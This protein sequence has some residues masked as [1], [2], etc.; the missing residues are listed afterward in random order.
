MKYR[1]LNLI[2][3][4]LLLT[5]C[6][7]SFLDR[8]PEG[9]YVDVTYYTSDNAL[10]QATAPLYNRAWFDL[11][12]RA[13]VPLGSNRANDNFSRWGYPEFTN[14]KV[15]ALSTNLADAWKGFYSVITISN[16]VISAVNTKCSEDVSE[17]A[18]NEAI[19]EA[20]LMRACAYFYMVRLWGPVIIIEDNDK[21][22]ANPIQPLNRE[23]DVLEFVIRDL[24][25]AAENLP[26]TPSAKGRVTSWG[27]KGMLAKVYLA[28]SGWNGGA[29]NESDLQKCKELAA[30]VINNSGLKLYD[31]YEDLFKY[32]HNNN[33]E[34]LIAMQWVPLGD[35]GVCNT[36]LADLAGNSKMTGGVN[37]WSSYQASI[38]MLQQYETADTLRRNA[39]FCTNGTY[40]PYICIADGGYTYDGTTSSIKKGVPGGPD[41]D[42][43]GYIQSMNSP[44]NTYILRLADVYLTYAEA[45]LGNN[46]VLNSGPGLEAL[47]LV[48]DRARI[49]RKTGVT[50]E[51]IIRE[52]RV[53]FS[54]EYCNWYD[55]VSWYHWKP[56]YMINYFMNQHRG[57]TVDRIIK[58][59]NG[60]LHFGK[61]DGDNFLEGIE[62]WSEPGENID[63]NKNNILMPYPESDVIQNPLLNEKPVAYV[64]NDK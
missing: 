3:S 23:E 7:D 22:V 30:D 33:P 14:F 61:Y 6:S 32:K 63:I 64:F 11:N 43:D 56:D 42:N 35:W 8:A 15:T 31:N 51:D 38:D 18:K 17:R 28:R 47:N 13:I 29:R 19:A 37:V 46:Q 45:C 27:A 48:R 49:P 16:S 24:T 62:N 50:F 25:Y 52:R 9:N 34:S 10:K 41:D 59:E 12:S 21:V 26:N 39:T 2:L 36:L 40:Y 53:E 1:F 60:N 5:A 58:D 55:M 44:L 4:L 20:K 57:Y 54:M